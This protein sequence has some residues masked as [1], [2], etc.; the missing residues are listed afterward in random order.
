MFINYNMDSQINL[1]TDNFKS[2]NN[3]DNF[4]II[5]Y[6]EPLCCEHKNL[7]SLENV[8]DIKNAIMQLSPE[9]KI[10]ILHM[11]EPPKIEPVIKHLR[12]RKKKK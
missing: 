5:D 11:L 3:Y 6:P 1:T 8:T 10:S 9:D 12:K 4:E 7:T 2:D